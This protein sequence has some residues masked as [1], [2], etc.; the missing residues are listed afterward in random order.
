M[1]TGST[2]F[3]QAKPGDLVTPIEDRC[4]LV[5]VIC[6]NIDDAIENCGLCLDA[7][8]AIN[9]MRIVFMGSPP[10]KQWL[11]HA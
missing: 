10:Q 1:K 3:K 8:V 7:D 6:E 4:I 2:S 5:F 11:C 9:E